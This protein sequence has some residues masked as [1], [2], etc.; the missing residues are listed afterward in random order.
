MREQS[1]S[2]S[3]EQLQH[4]LQLY[5][6]ENLQQALLAIEQLLASFPNSSLLHNIL[7]ATQLGLADID[8][9]IKSYQQAVRIQPNEA[10]TYFNLAIALTEKDD[11]DGAITCYKQALKLD[12]DYINAYINMGNAH[13]DAGDL[14]K[15]IDSYQQALR[16]DPDCAE[17]YNNLAN[18]LKDKGELEQAINSYRQAI[19]IRR[20]Y[21]EAYNNLGS[22]LKEKGS[23]EQAINSY[24][25]ALALRPDYTDAAWNLVGTAADIDAAEVWL[26]R[27]LAVDQ[28][29]VDAK[30]G[31]AVLRY[32]KGD[33]KDFDDLMRSSWRDHPS[34]RS[35]E[36][37]S[38][39]P[40]LPELYFNRW[41]FFDNIIALSNQERPFYEF[42]VFTG[43]S[44]K[45]LIKAYTSG[46]GFD[47]FEGLPEDWHEERA[48]SYSS[49]GRVPEVA[50]GEFVVGRFEETLPTFFAEPRPIASVINF[51]ADLY[52]STICAL[53]YAR[54]VIDSE[55]I[56]IFDE[57]IVNEHWEQDE[58]KALN[59]FCKENNC[60]YD[61][62]AVSFFTKQTAVRLTGI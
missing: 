35:M 24:Q 55:T 38:N 6:E 13:K 25:Q 43:E 27:C 18:A 47:T 50:G 20:D 34:M 45:Y 31:L 26:Q 57:F 9:A 56:L 39:L 61:V 29:Y 16:I 59:E 32:F 49:G 40:S 14:V 12:P 44:F 21:A 30:I 51:D 28:D 1:N 58:Y 33:S 19:Q 2:P 17:V 3:N 62:L 54:S 7:G 10:K 36:W 37:V 11:L 41:S 5:R 15:A 46:F 52:S 42:G 8:A 22:A 23:L 4:V 48:G 53:S 60:S